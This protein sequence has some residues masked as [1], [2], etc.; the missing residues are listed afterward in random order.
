MTAALFAFAI[1]LTMM[2]AASG[3]DNERILTV[4]TSVP[5]PI[6]HPAEAPDETTPYFDSQSAI[7]WVETF[8]KP[9]G[10]IAD[11]GSTG[12]TATRLFGRFGVESGYLVLD[13]G[14]S[15]G[16]L[17]TAPIDI[18]SAG[19]VDV[20]LHVSSEGPLEVHQDYVQVFVQVDGGDEQNIGQV[21]GQEA[22]TTI[23]GRDIVGNSLVVIVRAYVSWQKEFYHIDQLSVMHA[24]SNY[25]HDI[26]FYLV[27][28]FTDQDFYILEDD[29]TLILTQLGTDA[30]NVRVAPGFPL[31]IGSVVF[32]YD[33]KPWRTENWSPYSFAGD[34]DVDYNAWTPK[35]GRHSIEA[36]I[37]SEKYGA[38]AVV[39]RETIQFNVVE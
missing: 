12:W 23:T 38:G 15:V 28:A 7:P 36:I 4:P 6:S 8:S 37:Y 11:Y 21:K 30:L 27:N 3:L 19:A 5:P 9:D 35:L 10:T 25:H 32:N 13:G 17:E 20:S 39:S 1:A 16:V 33:G 14:G 34:K 22:G 2:G 29:M 31:K 24:A 26:V 18:S